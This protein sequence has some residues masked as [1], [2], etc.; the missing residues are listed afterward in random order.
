VPGVDSA[1]VRIVPLVPEPLT[2]EGE[3]RLRDLVRAA[4]QWRRKQ[5]RKILRD[6]PDLS[7][8][9]EV[10]E[11]AAQAASVD[12]S[13]RPERVA[14]EQ[15]VVLARTLRWPEPPAGRVARA[16]PPS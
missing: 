4:F 2:A 6:H 9:E 12:L 3:R 16:G 11:T 1:V 15:F 5:L 8:A 13:D 14:P 7:V 10:M